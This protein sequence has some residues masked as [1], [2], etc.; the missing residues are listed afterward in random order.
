LE[1][2]DAI[3]ILAL[4]DE[5]VCFVLV[6]DALGVCF[7]VDV[8]F[9]VLHVVVGAPSAEGSSDRISRPMMANEVKNRMAGGVLRDS[10]ERK[11]G[12]IHV[13][14]IQR[15]VIWKKYN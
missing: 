14:H 9:G 1:V 4:E 3:V 2:A 5:D 6:A 13:E 15:E 12:D 10:K 8:G 7:G 11:H